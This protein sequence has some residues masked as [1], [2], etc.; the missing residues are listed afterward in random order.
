MVVEVIVD[1]V[2]EVVLELVVDDFEVVVCEVVL[3]DVEVVDA[4]A[5]VVVDEEEELEEV[6]E[7]LGT[8]EA[9]DEVKEEL[10]DA[11]G[12]MTSSITPKSLP[13]AV[14]N[15]RTAPEIEAERTSY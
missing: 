7:G 13:C 10:E 1:D 4:D 15:D 9:P 14:P 6:L 11:P 3:G 8:P 2:I 5:E 12:L